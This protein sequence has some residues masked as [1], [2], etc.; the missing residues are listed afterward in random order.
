MTPLERYRATLNGET[1]DPIV[2]CP[3]LMRF[4]AEH[5][6]HTYEEFLRDHRVLVEANLQCA[7]DFGYDQLSMISDPVRETEGFGGRTVYLPNSVPICHG[8]LEAEEE[9]E[10]GRLTAPDP[11]LSPRMKD[12]IDGVRLMRE[13]AGDQYSILGWVE[14]PTS[15]ACDLRGMANFFMDLLEEPEACG[16]LLDMT[17]DAAIAFA[18]AQLEA[19]ADSIG[20]GEAVASQLSAETYRDLCLPRMQDL[21][22]AIREAGG[23]V[24]LHICGNITHLLPDL[25]T[26]GIHILDID[27]MVDPAEVRSVM[28]PETVLCTHVNPAGILQSGTPDGIRDAL[29]DDVQTLGAPCMIN[30]GCEIPAG[31]PPDLLRAFCAPLSYPELQTS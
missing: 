16:E 26:L 1:V 29:V 20:I 9:L 25:A 23:I 27:H 4:A 7:E 28:G 11:Y 15:E 12:W 22:T 24:K 14:G 5:I 21:V 18:R 3:I 8:P 6:G 2:R 13:R 19:G 31:T 17:R 30:A 10:P